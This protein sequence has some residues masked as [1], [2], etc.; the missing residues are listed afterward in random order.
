[1]STNQAPWSIRKGIFRSTGQSDFV[2][3]RTP[4]PVVEMPLTPQTPKLTI[5]T[6]PLSPR[7]L[8]VEKPLE[9]RPI[10][11][12]TIREIPIEKI[13]VTFSYNINSFGIRS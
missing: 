4:S 6:N 1:M 10:T 9:V 7:I 12:K 8:I 13:E 11:V 2:P 3:T 5:N